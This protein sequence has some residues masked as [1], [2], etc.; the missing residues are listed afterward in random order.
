[1]PYFAA[2][3]GITLIAVLAGCGGS[4]PSPSSTAVPSVNLSAS[5]GISPAQACNAAK[6]AWSTFNS[7]YTAA[8]DDTSKAQV[9]TQYGVTFA[10]IAFA[11][12]ANALISPTNGLADATL[13]KD[14][15]AAGSAA[16]P[17]AGDLFKGNAKAAAALIPGQFTTDYNDFETAAC[18]TAS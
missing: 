17:I 16:G 5:D 15:D 8:A 3:P 9:A 6:G 18:G 12:S 14:A 13:E 4:G 7:A 2:V 1:M 10:A 11:L